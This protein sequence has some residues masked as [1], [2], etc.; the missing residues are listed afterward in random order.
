MYA[1]TLFLGNTKELVEILD[2]AVLGSI[3]IVS[4]GKMLLFTFVFSSFVVST[5]GNVAEEKTTKIHN[6]LFPQYG[7]NFRYEGE[8][9]NK[10]DRVPIVISIPL[11]N[12]NTLKLNKLEF[13]NCSGEFFQKIM[14]KTEKDRHSRQGMQNLNTLNT[15]RSWC[16]KVSPFIR[17]L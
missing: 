14:A 11:P 10:L 6:R 16:T 13:S 2:L 15:M 5:F 4:S 8:L 17:L 7:V 12:Y 1:W 3:P 9:F